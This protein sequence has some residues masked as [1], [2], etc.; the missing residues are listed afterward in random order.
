MRG[1]RRIVV[2]A[3]AAV[4]AAVAVVL[5]VRACAQEGPREILGRL[6]PA[7]SGVVRVEVA[8]QLSGLAALA[9]PV[10][11]TLEGPFVDQR[12]GTIPQLDLE[13]D[14]SGAGR[15]LE[16]GVVVLDRTFVRYE[17]RDYVLAPSDERVVRDVY[18]GSLEALPPFLRRV[19]PGPFDPGPEARLGEDEE[20]GGEKLTRI[21][22]PLD[23]RAMVA[24]LDRILDRQRGGNPLTEEQRRQITDAVRDPR[25]SVSVADDDTV[26]RAEVTALIRLP[27][28]LREQLGGIGGGT[29]TV[30]LGYRDLGRPQRI[31]APAD[32]LPAARLERELRRRAGL[33]AGL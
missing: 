5:V 31:E 15:R 9:G 13:L 18:R 11:L 10:Q 26:R 2:L 6:K 19:H 33:G 20:V 17:G 29:L 24:V 32:P 16:G 27:P 21:E 23:V 7:P 28:A 25:W 3:L 30:T 1:R 14:A 8:V 12:P 4:V 22:G